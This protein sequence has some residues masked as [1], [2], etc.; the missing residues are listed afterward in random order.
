MN[1]YVIPTVYQGMYNALTRLV[2]SFSSLGIA[3][4]VVPFGPSA[5]SYAIC[6]LMFSDVL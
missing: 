6:E 4:L 1:G 3:N 5:S 2:E